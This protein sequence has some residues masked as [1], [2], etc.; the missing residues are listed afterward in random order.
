MAIL[1]VR[2]LPKSTCHYNLVKKDQFN[3]ANLL[4]DKYKNYLMKTMGIMDIV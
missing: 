1:E 2:K 3:K 4:E